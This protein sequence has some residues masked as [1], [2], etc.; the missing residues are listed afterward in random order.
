MLT[1]ETIIKEFE[2]VGTILYDWSKSFKSNSSYDLFITID[3]CGYRVASYSLKT[4]RVIL[5]CPD[6]HIPQ[7]SVIEKFI[8]YV[9]AKGE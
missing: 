1:K 7:S 4:K 3:N 9:K 2:K 5:H 6:I 8:E